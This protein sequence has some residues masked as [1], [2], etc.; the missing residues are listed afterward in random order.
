[1]NYIRV[2]ILACL[3]VSASLANAQQYM[4]NYLTTVDLGRPVTNLLMVEDNA[5]GGGSVTW[6]FTAEGESTTL[7][8]NPFPSDFPVTS[9][10]LIGLVQDLDGDPSGQKH[11][12]LFMNDDAASNVQH[13][14]WG[15]IF[16][17]T[18]EPQLI[19]DIELATS[20]QDWEIIQPG[21]D[22]VWEFAQAAKSARVGPGGQ[23]GSAWFDMEGGFSLVAFSDGQT[24]GSGTSYN[25]VVPEPASLAALGVGALALI[26]RKRRSA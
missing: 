4:S 18:L 12:V 15:T 14:A 5:G 1:M 13:I 7:L 10:L 2:S 11:V 20:G 23:E 26:R 19:A 24:I 6:A 3:A 16:T 8:S 21:L 25:S 17:T 22:G 9:S